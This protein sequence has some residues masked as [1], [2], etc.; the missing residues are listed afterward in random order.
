MTSPIWTGSIFS[1]S[2]RVGVTCL[3]VRLSDTDSNLHHGKDGRSLVGGSLTATKTY[4][5]H[6]VVQRDL[7]R[8][9]LKLQKYILWLE[10]DFKLAVT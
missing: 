4:H 6:F 8:L 10:P 3:S 1:L 2:N 7:L 5:N 9:K